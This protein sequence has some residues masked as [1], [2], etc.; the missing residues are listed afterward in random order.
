MRY[1]GL[2]TASGALTL[3]RDVQNGLLTGTTLGT[4][5]TTNSYNEFGEVTS[6]ASSAPFAVTGTQYLIISL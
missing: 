6:F 1:D 5:T 3:N 4:T 2:L